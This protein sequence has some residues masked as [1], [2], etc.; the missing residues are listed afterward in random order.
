MSVSRNLVRLALLAGLGLA[1]SLVARPVEASPA[2]EVGCTYCPDQCPANQWEGQI[3]CIM[4][5][6]GLNF[7]VCHENECANVRVHCTSYEQ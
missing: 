4:Y 3:G 6:Q 7:N 5:C 2:R 1:S